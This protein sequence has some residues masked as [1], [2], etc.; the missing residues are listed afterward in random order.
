MG[1]FAGTVAPSVALRGAL[2]RGLLGS[3]NLVAAGSHRERE[4]RET[5]QFFSQQTGVD[6]LLSGQLELLSPPPPRS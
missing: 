1:Q 6:V 2:S 5:L 4:H 3:P